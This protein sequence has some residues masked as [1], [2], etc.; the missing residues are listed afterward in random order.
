MGYNEKQTAETACNLPSH[1]ASPANQSDADTAKGT[2]PKQSIQKEK[3][4][5]RYAAI[6]LTLV[7]LSGKY[8][9]G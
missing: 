8:T 5:C 9:I 4:Q 1:K 3:Q 2:G 7:R 6:R